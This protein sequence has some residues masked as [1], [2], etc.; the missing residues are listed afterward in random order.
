MADSS[1]ETRFWLDKLPHPL[2]W[3]ETNDVPQH[4]YRMITIPARKLAPVTYSAFVSVSGEDFAVAR[5][6]MVVSFCSI[7]AAHN[8]APTSSSQQY[9]I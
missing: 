7:S 1:L 3:H 9:R 8:A 6:V 4:P 5:L 2:E